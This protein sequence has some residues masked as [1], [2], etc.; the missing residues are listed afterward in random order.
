MTYSPISA[1]QAQLDQHGLLPKAVVETDQD[2]AGQALSQANE[3]RRGRWEK[4]LSPHWGALIE[5]WLSAPLRHAAQ[6]SPSPAPVAAAWA[7]A[8][9]PGFA[10][11]VQSITGLALPMFLT[12]LVEAA[13]GRRHGT[14]PMPE[15]ALL[16][17]L[18]AAL[19]E[20]VDSPPSLA[21]WFEDVRLSCVRADA[22][23]DRR[24]ACL[25]AQDVEKGLIEVLEANVAGR[26]QEFLNFRRLGNG[27]VAC[28]PGAFDTSD[29]MLKSGRAWLISGDV[30]KTLNPGQAFPSLGLSVFKGLSKQ[31]RA[32]DESEQQNVKKW[33]LDSLQL[34]LP[35]LLGQPL[36]TAEVLRQVRE[37]L[38]CGSHAV[39]LAPAPRLRPAM[40]GEDGFL[41]ASR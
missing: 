14:L 40:T 11:S 27:I 6:Q 32:D 38:Q 10:I 20:S 19:D 7:A 15:S 3:A 39:S 37:S 26:A 23:E 24:Q 8:L 36:D 12:G 17:T 16:N 22:L 1:L 18:I 31:L 5:G 41:I 13:A 2:H 28:L 4:E 33:I 21:A 35:S 34:A 29:F 25:R 30:M 9:S